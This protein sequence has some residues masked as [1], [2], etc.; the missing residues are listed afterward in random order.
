[1]NT[2]WEILYARQLPLSYRAPGI[3]GEFSGSSAPV[4]VLSQPALREVLGL[5][6]GG[7]GNLRLSWNA[8]PGALCYNVYRVVGVDLYEIQAQCISDPFYDLTDFGD[9]S[10]TAIT[11]EGETPFSDPITFS[12][13][14]GGVSTVTVEAACKMA[15][16]NTFP[17]TFMI[18]RD[19]VTPVNLTVNFSLAGTAVNGVDYDLIPFSAT[20]PAGS[21]SVTVDI[22]PVEAAFTVG[23]TIVLTLTESLTYAVG[24]PNSASVFIRPPLLRIAD[25]G[26]L[27]PLLQPGEP[28]SPDYPVTPAVSDGCEWDGS[29]NDLRTD[30]TPSEVYQYRDSEGHRGGTGIGTP[31]LAE[32]IQGTAFALAIM[33][34]P[35]ST[36]AVEW[37]VA[38]YGR[39]D[40][41]DFYVIWT[42][43]KAPAPGSQADGIYL[44]SGALGNQS[45][46]RPTLEFE[47]V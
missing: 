47:F 25:Y 2:V 3:C 10:V 36:P 22:A 5:I 27:Q 11:P 8:F 17:A 33:G 21:D 38:I 12:G 16:S 4:I 9:Y 40:D 7:F 14:G 44:R 32:S 39:T 19:A 45:D 35:Y 37:Q 13:G 1:M 20:I 18:S 42:G 29:L 15:S 28:D 24:T 26:T 6:L 23:K 31:P 34:G 30:L 43:T 41:G 46:L